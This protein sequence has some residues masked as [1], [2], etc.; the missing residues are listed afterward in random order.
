MSRVQLAVNV[1]DLADADV[2]HGDDG[3]PTPQTATIGTAGNGSS[4]C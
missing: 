3:M 4:C 2:L 1:G